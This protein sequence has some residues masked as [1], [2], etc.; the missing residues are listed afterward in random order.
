MIN[1]FKK[2]LSFSCFCLLTTQIAWSQSA[3]ITSYNCTGAGSAN[4]SI[5]PTTG[6]TSYSWRVTGT[7]AII[8]TT[9]TSV[10]P[11]GS[12]SITI[13]RNGVTSTLN[14]TVASG[15]IPTTPAITPASVSTPICGSSTQVLNSTTASNYTWKRDGVN[16]S[17]S[18]NSI[19]ATGNDVSS[20]GIFRYTVSTTNPVSGCT[21]TSNTVE[22]SMSPTLAAPTIS[23]NDGNTLICGSSTQ[24]LNASGGG[25]EY[26]W[27]RGSTTLPS[28][29]S[30]ITVTGTDAT[31]T[32]VYTAAIA[33]S[34][35]CPLNFST[36]GV[37]LTLSPGVATPT[38]TT[39]AT[40]N[41]VCGTSTQI[42]T[43]SG[44]GTTYSWKRSG[45]PV[46]GS[47]NSIT[48]TGNDVS[49]A[50]TY[51]YTVSSQN[52]AG[53]ISAESAPY[54]LKVSPK[55]AT[56]NVTP[57]DAITLL[58]GAS[59]QVLNASGGGTSY[60][61]KRGNTTLPTTNSSLTVSGNDETGTFPFTVSLINSVG[62]VSDVSSGISLTLSPGIATPNITTPTTTNPVCGTAT[63]ILTASAGGATYSWKR[64]GIAITGSTN[65]ITVTGNDVSVANTYN[66]T[67]SLQNAV[68]CVSP[69]S[70]PYVLKVSPK[71]VT[72]TITPAVFTPNIVC[73]TDSKTLTAIEI[74]GAIYTWK[75]NGLNQSDLVTNSIV[76]R[77]VDIPSGT[78]NY[79]VSYSNSVGCLSDESLPVVLVFV[80]AIPK[81]TI[82]TTT[83]VTFCE[84]GS[85]R[86]NST[87]N[88]SGGSNIWTKTLGSS[89]SDT[90]TLGADGVSVRSV[91]ENF[92]T[93]RAR[94]ANSCSSVPS[95]RFKVT[96]NALPSR[97]VIDKGSANAICDLDSITL[98][99]NNKGT[100]GYVWNTG[101]TATSITVRTAGSYSLTF[102]DAN[103]CTSLP[104]T[105]FVLT[106]N[107]LPAKPTI[108]NLNRSEFCFREFTTLRAASTTA[109]T[110][111]EWDYFNRTGNQIDVS[112]SS[113]KT[114]NEI[115][116]IKVRAVSTFTNSTIS[117]V[118][119]SRE[120]SDETVIT[121]KPLPTTPTISTSGPVIFCPD[122]TVS[123]T[124][125]DSPNQ[126]YKW[127][128]TKNG[129]E[130]S[131]KKTVL[132]DTTSKNF[133]I[134][135]LGKIG[136][137]Y[138]QTIGQNACVSDTSQNVTVTVRN[139]PLKAVIN[140]FPI[141]ATVCK[142]GK[143]TLDAL[144]SNGNINRYSW[145][146]EKTKREIT[147][148]K[149]F[150]VD[151]SGT[152]SVRLRDI[153][154]C[155]AESSN[156]L[157]VN[158][159]PLPT[160][161]SITV[162][163]SKIFCDEDF[164]TLQSSQ[165]STTP[166]GK[167]VYTWIV[168]GQVISDSV[169]RTFSW[170]KAS[171][172]AVAVTDSNGC[173]A[174]AI[175]DTIKTTVNPLPASPSITVRG[176]IPFCADK[177]VTLSAI[178]T[179]GVTFKWSTGLT[180]PS[181]TTNSVGN[182]SVQ[183][184]NGFGC[185]SKPSQVVQ[186]RVFP[187]PAAPTLTANGVTT[188]CDGSRVRIISSS[189]FQALWFR[190]TTDSIGRGE[191][192]TSIFASKSGNYFAKVQDNNGCISLAST[193]IAVDARPNPTPTI[194]KQIGSFSLDAQGVG[195]ENGYIWRYNDVVKPE[196]TTRIIKAKQDGDY[197]VQASIT[198]TGLPIAGGR[199]VCYSNTS[200]PI[201]YLQDLSF[202]GFSIF[203]NPT[204][205]GE[206]NVEVVEDLIGATISV[207][208]LYG[209]L[210][211]EYEVDKFTTLR[212][213]ELPNFH[214][215]VF[216]VKITSDGYERTRRVITLKQ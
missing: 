163:K 139:A 160:K 101:R 150:E 185:L 73:S 108:T 56:P 135:P 168:D 23:A 199:L 166:N 201:K 16:I 52:A 192:L 3:V 35:G 145:R 107:P 7:T 76:L 174:V 28:T 153:F 83:P 155:F 171:S 87:Y 121:V 94:D 2:L 216:I 159:S 20:P 190:S 177:N 22:L 114:E 82:T 9:P 30:S 176:A 208:S 66:Y 125:T 49:V 32:F 8:A 24:T 178:G 37:S 179:A 68:G 86:L 149:T 181:I 195:D 55:P 39:P 205:N 167:N 109:G 204:T 57:R 130:F 196:L 33:N 128:N 36:T 146:D 27:R 50:N 77:G 1:L 75:R 103:S 118:C 41:P 14:S 19:T 117:N 43:A 206:I 81:P 157:T 78:Q 162:L 131:D 191:D 137:F 111:F 48:V 54:D 164:T 17:G 5:S 184:I 151:T 170:K 158:V 79:S 93:V 18:T 29:G 161:P 65:S 183:S 115:I 186:V 106:I 134:T 180:T 38:I 21:S 105:P 59:T 129:L 15:I 113:K 213:I 45:T 172:I 44:G 26:V 102:T 197:K 89:I 47:T 215:D 133:T 194:I 62:C 175:S 92:Y 143:V 67:V 104:S 188:F 210:I 119:K 112:G 207:Y 212:K 58:C 198:Y 203:P 4:I 90:I 84:G 189:S 152:Y 11:S 169:S 110:T 63:Q 209:Q 132:I 96:V 6:I 144:F 60:I 154:G 70:A 25:S 74:S 147:T 123:L 98:N 187:L 193:P 10:Q 124:S 140:P 95:E 200:Q 80:A 91:G 88:V 64:S 42:L 61:W 40:A 71:P 99:S 116:R 214:G 138:V 148:L 85:V 31:G 156:P 211:S 53:C 165:P 12:Y 173:K 97:P 51:N 34:V 72:P 120:L 136:K 126:I 141:S 127:I 142:G 100:G 69:E 13:V 182:I 46:S 122:S 202:S